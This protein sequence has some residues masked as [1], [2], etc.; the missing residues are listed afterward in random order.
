MIQISDK[1]KCSGC[2]ACASICPKHCIEMKADEEGFFYPY[3]DMS[4]CMKCNACDVVCPIQN[5]IVSEERY[6]T[7]FYAAQNKDLTV[8]QESTAGGVFSLIATYIINAGGIV[9][10]VGYDKMVVSHFSTESI[11]GLKGMR[12]SKYVQ[13]D[14]NDVFCQI[15]KSLE[16]RLVLFVGTP[17]QVHGLKRAIKN[18][19]NLVT[20]DLFCF[21]VSSP[22]IFNMWI[23]YLESKYKTEVCDIQFRNKHYGYSTPNVRVF[24]Q[25]GKSFD[26]KYDSKS[27]ANT[28]FRNLNVRLSCYECPFREVSRV[29][30]FT[31]GDFNEIRAFNSNLDDD[32][33]TTKFYVHTEKG[34]AIVENIREEMEL[35]LIEKNISSIVG[36]KQK[37][38]RKPESREAFFLDANVL[39]YNRLVTKWVPE[40]FKSRVASIA[41]PVINN[42]PFKKAVFSYIRRYK[43]RK[44][45][46]TV[47]EVNR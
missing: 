42:L 39:N 31:I 19:E 28:F 43:T 40:T 25:N 10:A 1:T 45:D 41:R 30:D 36:G 37:Q 38:Y 47:K 12:G 3:V 20:I 26:Q 14:L 17:C 18:T 24:F 35:I 44:F 34:K 2:T 27:Y 15:R 16:N 11:L 21:G 22:K 9:Y 13:S 4:L 33:G 7:D 5:N 29:S 46:K 32:V 6:N 8:R 23:N